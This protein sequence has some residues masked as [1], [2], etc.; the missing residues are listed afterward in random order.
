[1]DGSLAI[2]T[3]SAALVGVAACAMEDVAE[4]PASDS[5]PQ[6]LEGTLET[7]AG[8]SLFAVNIDP[9]NEAAWQHSTPAT[10]ASEFDGVRLTS[11]ASIQGRIDELKAAGLQVMAI[12]TGESEGYVPHNADLLQIG[13]EP[14]LEATAMSPAHYADEWVVYRNSYPQ[15]A[16][17]F[18]MAG[19]ASG[20]ENAVSYAA[21]VFEAIGGRAP[22]PDMVAIHPYTKTPAGAAHDIDLM[23]NAFGIPVIATEWHNDTDTWNFQ[24]MLAN[25]ND[26]RSTSW[27]SV[28]AYTDAMVPGFGLRDESGAPKPFYYSLL[29]APSECR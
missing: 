2:A 16:G 21:A 26:G 23:W 19:L 4:A 22:L 5:I 10:V 7:G 15:F 14:D 28:F 3:M 17:R 11:R 6:S 8:P 20:G 12:V 13:N 24:C 25:P 29:S 18:V 9:A 27:S 1:M